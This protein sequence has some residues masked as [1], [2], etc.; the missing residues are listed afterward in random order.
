MENL[1]GGIKIYCGDLYFNYC[2]INIGD[3][4]ILALLTF[5]EVF[6]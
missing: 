5:M 1:I 3:K 2:F 6:H 4:G